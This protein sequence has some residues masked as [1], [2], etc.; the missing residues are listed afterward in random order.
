MRAAPVLSLAPR[1]PVPGATGNPTV[2]PTARV[3]LITP[4]P[5]PAAPSASSPVATTTP[6]ASATAEA[7]IAA[8]PLSLVLTPS[9]G[10]NDTAIT[11]NGTGW[12]PGAAVTVTYVQAV[13]G[14]PGSTATATVDTQGRFTAALTTHDAQALPGAHQ[15]R[16]QDDM[17]QATASFTATG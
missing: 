3:F 17:H 16:A 1:A 4:T 13:T 8:E 7:T 6:S 15:V 10:P 2:R 14:T 9:S 11:V 12:T 5:T